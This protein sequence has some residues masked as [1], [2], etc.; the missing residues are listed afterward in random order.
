MA[1]MQR[2]GQLFG[3]GRMFLPQVVK[4]A[5]TMKQ[6][7]EILTI[8]NSQLTIDNSQL[9]IDKVRASERDANLFA[10]SQRAQP[11]LSEPN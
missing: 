8:H 7:V 2:G 11:K 1:G 3:E 6:A 4:T 10:I 9:T 5:R